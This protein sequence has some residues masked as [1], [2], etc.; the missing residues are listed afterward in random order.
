M[1]V[2]IVSIRIRICFA[3]RE[4]IFVVHTDHRFYY[5]KLTYSV[6]SCSHSSLSLSLL[7]TLDILDC[8][9]LRVYAFLCSIH[10]VC[11]CVYWNLLHIHWACVL[12]LTVCCLFAQIYGY[13]ICFWSI[14]RPAQCGLHRL[15]ES[16]SLSDF[17]QFIQLCSQLNR[18]YITSKRHVCVCD[19]DKFSFFIKYKS[20]WKIHIFCLLWKIP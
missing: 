17:N 8:Y 6:F 19:P 15:I 7:F 14:N 10:C 5:N 11:R 20:I 9:P 1:Y 4:W 18:D 2:T 3:P 13:N 12:I 16:D